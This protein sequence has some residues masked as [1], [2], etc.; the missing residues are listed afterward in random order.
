MRRYKEHCFH[1]NCWNEKPYIICSS[2]E[3]VIQQKDSCYERN[4]TKC[5]AATIPLKKGVFYYSTAVYTTKNGTH[6]HVFVFLIGHRRGDKALKECDDDLWEINKHKQEFQQIWF[7]T[8]VGIAS[9][10]LTAF[11]FVFLMRFRTC[12]IIIQRITGNYLWEGSRIVSGYNR[13]IGTRDR[14]RAGSDP[15]PAS[16]ATNSS[17][18]KNS[19]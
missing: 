15:G 1:K 6:D 13:G 4:T 17:G 9:C 2:E 18:S 7:P 10:F 5:D 11:V 16:P 12:T 8:I 19:G 3:G 14:R